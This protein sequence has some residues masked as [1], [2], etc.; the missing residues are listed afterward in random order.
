MF[1]PNIYNLDTIQTRLDRAQKYV[2]DAEVRDIMTGGVSKKSKE[3]INTMDVHNGL[4]EGVWSYQLLR[5]V[6]DKTNVDETKQVDL[7]SRYIQAIKVLEN[8]PKKFFTWSVD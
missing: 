4:E 2:P 5:Y 1:D 6:T 3:L 7:I 8:Q